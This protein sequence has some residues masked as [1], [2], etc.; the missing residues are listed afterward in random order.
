[1]LGR[2]PPVIDETQSDELIFLTELLIAFA[3]EGSATLA[4]RH[5]YG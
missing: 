5:C 4:V 3:F 1:V 2:A